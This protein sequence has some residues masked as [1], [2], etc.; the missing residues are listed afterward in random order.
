MTLDTHQDDLVVVG[1]D[2]TKETITLAATG[3]VQFGEQ[4]GYDTH[5]YETIELTPELAKRLGDDLTEAAEQLL[6]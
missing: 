2:E 4:D 1:V 6:D 5:T 3:D